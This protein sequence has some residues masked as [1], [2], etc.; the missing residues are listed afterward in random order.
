[1][2]LLLDTHAMLWWVSGEGLDPEAARV[3]A[4]PSNLALV[5]AVS[6]WE[7]SI[8]QALGKLDLTVSLDG[9]L[10]AV[11]ADFDP[12][13]VDW[14]HGLL[15]GQLPPHHRDPF[16]RLLLAQAMAEGLTVVTRDRAFEPYG[17]PL[18]RA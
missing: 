10:D 1:V 4:E 5:S 3:I 17:V 15:A 2:R 13:A 11:A 18:L 6:L 7:V 14:R 16:D 12:L 9:L 8:K